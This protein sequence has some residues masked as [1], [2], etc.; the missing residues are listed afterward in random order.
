MAKSKRSMNP[1]DAMRKQQRK[2][3]LKK[4]K[5]ARKNLRENVLAKKDVGKVKQEIARL[6]HLVFFLCIKKRA[7][8]AY[9]ARMQENEKKSEK[10]ARKL[11]YDPKSGKFV[12]AKKKGK[13]HNFFF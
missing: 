3:E 5:E 11:V 7:Q 10:E 6:E 9:A 2:R 12:P 1:A 8:A 4:N 13:T